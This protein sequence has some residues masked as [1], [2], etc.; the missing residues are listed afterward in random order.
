MLMLNRYKAPNKGLWNG[1]GGKIHEGETPEECIIREVEEETGLLIEAPGFTGTVQWEFDYQFIG[2]MYV[3]IVYLEKETSY[4]T[5]VKVD[6]GLLDWKP[7]KWVLESDNYGVVS[8]IRYF[9]PD[10]LKGEEPAEYHCYYHS[11]K[12]SGVKKMEPL[13]K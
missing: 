10:M 9:L 1:V 11:G 2:G 3:Y 8:N 4:P 6:E 7:I 12:L 13:Q 5:P